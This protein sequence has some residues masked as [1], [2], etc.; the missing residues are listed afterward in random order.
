MA[1]ELLTFNDQPV[2]F[3]PPDDQDDNFVSF[4]IIRGT[5][6]TCPKL[7]LGQRIGT[8]ALDRFRRRRWLVLQPEQ[9]SC[10]QNS[11]IT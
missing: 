2:A 4:D 3:F 11:L 6:V 5:Q 1:I 9:D 8:Q 7:G 10:F